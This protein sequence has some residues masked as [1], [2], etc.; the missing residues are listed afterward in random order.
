MTA[1]IRILSYR[2]SRILNRS[3]PDKTKV[4]SAD[5]TF[6]LREIGDIIRAALIMTAP[7]QTKR[8]K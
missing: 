3:I 1:Q 5:S 2:Y 4:E 6:S 7:E 8:V